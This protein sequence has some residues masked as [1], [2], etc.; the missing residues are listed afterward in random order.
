M[1]ATILHFP[2]MTER[3]NRIYQLRTERGLSQQELGEM[4]GCSKMHVSGM[5]RGVR[6]VTL[7][8]MQRI[9]DALGV[10][11]SDVMNEDDNPLRLTPDERRLIERYRSAD[12]AAKQNIQRVTEALSPFA[13]EPE[14]DAA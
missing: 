8:W 5:E 7:T 12:D 2:A 9:A 10:D 6:E 13:R 4:I 1:S 3:P 14:Q 11:P